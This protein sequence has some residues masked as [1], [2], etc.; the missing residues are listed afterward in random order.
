[1]VVSIGGVSRTI[2][3]SQ[4]GEPV[5]L[6]NNVG[7]WTAEYNSGL[8]K[9]VSVSSNVDW[10]VRDNVSW[11]TVSPTGGSKNSSFTIRCSSNSSV[12]SRNG[13]VTISGGGKSSTVS[14]SQKGVPKTLSVSTTSWSVPFNSSLSKEISVSS[15][16]SW[17]VSSS[18]SWIKLSKTSGSGNSSFVIVCDPNS[19]PYDRVG[20][21]EVKGSGVSTRTIS[22]TQ[23]E[24]PELK[25]ARSSIIAPYTGATKEIQVIGNE[26][27]NVLSYPSWLVV[28]TITG[29]GLTY[30]S[31]DEGSEMEDNPNV[32]VSVRVL[33]NSSINS[34]SG[35]VVIKSIRTRATLNV[36]QNGAPANLTL[37]NSSWSFPF[38][39]S[40]RKTITVTSNTNWTVTE[41]ISWLSVS[42]SGSSFTIICQANTSTSG[43]SGTITVS[44]GGLSRTLQVSQS[45]VA[46]ILGLSKSFVQVD[47]GG[48]P[49][50]RV[51]VTCNTNWTLTKQGSWIRVS[52]VSGRGNGYFSVDAPYHNSSSNRSGWIIVKAGDKQ[53]RV[54][55]IQTGKSGGGGGPVKHEDDNDLGF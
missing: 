14:V 50:T 51:D 42:K 36:T 53:V 34:R 48:N 7:S 32:A 22:I 49:I 13:T 29:D 28:E 24:A 54:R 40:L 44:G 21:V 17:T 6:T 33:S 46:T 35:K 8:S 9:T 16:T 38:R 15:N 12:E 31:S 25:F 52:S 27:W 55:V 37:S 11:I 20:K 1:V 10:L 45:G 23:K 43:R 30:S 39:S 18:S 2:P 5:S 3:V 47:N 26:E 41:N 19:L 4:D